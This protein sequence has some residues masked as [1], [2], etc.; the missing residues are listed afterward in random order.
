MEGR[1]LASPPPACL[2]F[3]PQATRETFIARNRISSSLKD[4]GRREGETK[5]TVHSAPILAGLAL[6][7]VRPTNLLPLRKESTWYQ[8]FNKDC[9]TYRRRHLIRFTG[10]TEGHA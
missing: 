9:N 10:R 3:T 6:I 5:F 1:K 4:E 7:V 2:L 8:L